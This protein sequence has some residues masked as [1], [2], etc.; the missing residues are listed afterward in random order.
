MLGLKDGFMHIFSKFQAQDGVR[1]HIED[2][3]WTLK[4][5]DLENTFISTIGHK[6]LLSFKQKNQFDFFKEVK[7]LKFMLRL[8]N[9]K[10]ELDNHG[11]STHNLNISLRSETQLQQE[12]TR[13]YQQQ[14]KI[15]E[16]IGKF[17]ISI[18][19]NFK[20]FPNMTISSPLDETK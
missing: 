14:I 17:D 16:S 9:D 8:I 3:I 1:R 6:Y 20:N 4:T 5:F 12:L 15:N 7:D 10:K 13:Q 2:L 18:L 11:Q 19:G